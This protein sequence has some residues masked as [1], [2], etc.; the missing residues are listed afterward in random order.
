MQT[1][2]ISLR[3]LKFATV[4][5]VALAGPMAG[6][7]VEERYRAPENWLSYDRDNTGRRYSELAQINRENIERLVPKWSFQYNPLPPRSEAT[8]LIRDGVMYLTAGGM[9]AFAL[10]AASGHIVWRFDYPYSQGRGS[11]NPNWSR[12]FGLSG[13]LLFLGTPD[14]H[15]IALDSRSGS[16]RWRSAVTADQRCIASV[17]APV[18]A[19]NRVLMGIS[20]GDTGRIRGY[21]DAFNAET[22]K[23]E[24]RFH[25]VPEPGAPGSETWPG[26]GAWKFGGGTPWTS[27]TYDPEFD[28]LYWPT[29]NPGP[30]DF[31][32]RNREGDNLYTASL[33][34]LRPDNGE[35]VWHFQF[36]PHDV[37]DWDANQ[38]PV[39][40]DAE[41]RGQRRK[42]VLQA[43][44]N[45]FYYVL[46]RESG[47][48]LLSAPF[49]K[50]NWLEGFS[51]AGRPRPKPEADPSPTGSFVC[52]DIHGGTNWQSP[53]FHPGTELLYV[54]ARDACGLYYLTG[55]S[56]DHQETGAQN[57]LRAIELRTG[58]VRWEIPFLGAENEEVTFAGAM[59]TAG[60][61]VFFSSR[62]GTFM[63]ADADSGK[64]LWHFNTGGTIRAS[65]VTYAADGKQFVAITTK[66]GVFA[67]GL[68]E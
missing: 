4:A 48:F 3:W 53:A 64:V 39:L 47:D 67:F 68:F 55:H 49:A 43:N 2:P 15:L 28:L 16:M 36:T 26:T 22:G 5:G 29:G 44:R 63:A 33:L 45:G 35:L 66:S 31:D 13:Q 9:R 20:G 59:A 8:P 40:V 58:K 24:W 19:K 25:T 50:Q 56:V 46:D 30:K 10:D 41:W 65:P 1:L 37:H 23:R 38:T 6:Q 18:V 61:L 34:A 11:R 14:C 52:P 12:G 21:L 42:L 54:M 60:G 7:T 27:G 62:D 17:S 51:E 57:F 32:G